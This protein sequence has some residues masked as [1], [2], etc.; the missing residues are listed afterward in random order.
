MTQAIQIEESLNLFK[1]TLNKP[2]HVNTRQLSDYITVL[3]RRGG[4]S[5]LAPSAVAL[6]R[7]R[8]DPLMPFVMLCIGLPLAL[9]YGRQNAV[10]ALAL[11]VGITLLLWGVVSGF[12]HLGVYGLLP[13]FAAAWTPL[14]IFG[15]IGL[16]TMSRTA[17]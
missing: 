16:Y 9:V 8:S 2:S 6:E 5:S 7:K 3:K 11:A 10:T 17:T 1:P 14:A 13:P 12:Q 15:A 4:Q